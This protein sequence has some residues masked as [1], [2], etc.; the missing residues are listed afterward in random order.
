MAFYT[1]GILYCW[2]IGTAQVHI[3][4][5]KFT[6]KQHYEQQVTARMFQA[7]TCRLPVLVR[8]WPQIK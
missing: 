6:C 3:A 8:H 5:L 4:L 2:Y 1:Q 7:Q